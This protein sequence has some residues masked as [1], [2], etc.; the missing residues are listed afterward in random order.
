VP[1]PSR[2]EGRGFFFAWRGPEQRPLLPGWTWHRWKR[3]ASAPRNSR[4]EKMGFSPGGSSCPTPRKSPQAH[5]DFFSS[6]IVTVRTTYKERP[7]MACRTAMPDSE[8]A[9]RW[10]RRGV[11]SL[12][13]ATMLGDLLGYV[14][15][16]RRG[17]IYSPRRLQAGRAR[18]SFLATPCHRP[19]PCEPR[20]PSRKSGLIKCHT[21]QSNSSRNFMKKK[22]RAPKE[23]SHFFEPAPSA[24]FAFRGFRQ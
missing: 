23:V 5:V 13:P 22:D 14:R 12:R 20:V 8:A 17:T 19:R 11:A 2:S 15:P 10:F 24:F 16:F 7:E 4:Q 3:G 9:G 18:Q 21:M 1:R 6:P